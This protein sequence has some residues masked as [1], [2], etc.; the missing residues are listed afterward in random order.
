M[1]TP[2][3]S[4][5][6]RRGGYQ[7]FRLRG[8]LKAHYKEPHGSAH[9]R[10]TQAGQGAAKRRQTPHSRGIGGRDR[11]HYTDTPRARATRQ[12]N[13]TS[14]RP[15]TVSERRSH[16]VKR[17]RS[18]PLASGETEWGWGLGTASMRIEGQ[19]KPA[20]VRTQAHRPLVAVATRSGSEEVL[21]REEEGPV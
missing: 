10:D 7:V 16:D 13:R 6:S 8:R 11:A 1:A 14:V 19:A 3:R 5:N 2:Q 9:L 21:R 20:R 17:G 18:K 4:Q 12:R 15:P